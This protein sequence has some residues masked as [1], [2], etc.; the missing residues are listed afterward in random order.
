MGKD[1]IA[2]ALCFCL[3]IALAGFSTWLYVEA[4]GLESKVS[5]LQVKTDDLEAQNAELS[6]KVQN[7]TWTLE[8][9]T[10]ITFGFMGSSSLTITNVTFNGSSGAG[11]NSVTLYVNNTGT[12]TVTVAQVKINNN[13]ATIDPSSLVT[14]P[15]GTNGTMLIDNVGWSNGNPY[16]FNL[17]D[18]SGNGLGSYQQNAP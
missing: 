2:L 7:L 14:Y 4:K 17:Y 6:A 10:D 5:D 18:S 9:L 16:M 15:A 11:T 8:N 1:K 13:L 3:I 12:E